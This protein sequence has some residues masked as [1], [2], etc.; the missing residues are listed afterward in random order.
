MAVIVA[1]A[2]R[3]DTLA[4]GKSRKAG[5]NQCRHDN[6]AGQGDDPN[7]FYPRRARHFTPR[8]FHFPSSQIEIDFQ[9]AIQISTVLLRP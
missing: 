8:A 5:Q 6:C 7:S 4:H 2:G 1:F 3:L 9:D